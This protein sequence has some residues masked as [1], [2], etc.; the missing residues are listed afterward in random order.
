MGEKSL[1]SVKLFEEPSPRLWTVGRPYLD[2]CAKLC[3]LIIKESVDFPLYQRVGMEVGIVDQ[4]GL[5][6]D[7]RKVLEK[8]L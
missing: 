4:E 8:W 5:W 6:S 3:K 7:K 1:H 2:S